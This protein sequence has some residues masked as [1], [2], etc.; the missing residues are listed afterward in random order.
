MMN[1]TLNGQQRELGC[2]LS[3]AELLDDLNLE[4][5]RVAVEV[6]R[7]L[8]SRGDFGLTTLDDGD[9]VEVVTLVGGG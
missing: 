8:I 7:Q 1:V 6:N 2:G 9:V 3:V 5:V 4:P